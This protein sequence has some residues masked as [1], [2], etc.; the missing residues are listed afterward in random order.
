MFAPFAPML[1]RA[2]LVPSV[3]RLL[4]SNSRSLYQNI[5]KRHEDMATEH[6]SPSSSGEMHDALDVLSSES[7]PISTIP[8]DPDTDYAALAIPSLQSKNKANL[9]PLMNIPPQEDPLL[10]HIASRIMN[11][12]ER[13]KASRTVSQMLLHLHAWT[14]SPPLPI[15]RQAIFK[16]SPAVKVIGH[17]HSTKMIYKPVPLSEKQGI[18]LATEWILDAIKGRQGGPTLAERMAR[19]VILILKNESKTLEKKEAYHKSAMMNRGNIA[20]ART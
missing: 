11:H 7:S 16:L 13:A 19:E 17:K 3:H 10:H 15:L 12:G 18:W 14:R 1:R 8:L 9:P 20:I 2:A 6:G 4:P 5:I